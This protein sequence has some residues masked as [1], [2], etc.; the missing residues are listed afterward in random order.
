MGF[1]TIRNGIQRTMRSV[2]KRGY[3]ATLKLGYGLLRAMIIDRWDLRFDRRLGIDTL[4]NPA[5][6]EYGSAQRLIFSR[7]MRG[8]ALDFSKFV[9][10]DLGCGKG[11]ALIL[12]ADLPFQEIIGVEY[13]QELVRTARRNL[14]HVAAKKPR[15]RDVELLCMDAGEYILP[16]RNIVLYL[17]DP[18]GP[19]VLCGVLSQ[20]Q[21]SMRRNPREIFVAYAEPSCEGFMASV[22]S[23]TQISAGQGY[24]IYRALPPAGD[25]RL[26]ADGQSGQTP[27]APQRTERTIHGE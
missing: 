4:A 6:P 10:I 18:F 17:Y 14:D 2:R 20:I 19:E 11:K 8:L 7:I 3:S 23:L 9:F 16:D 5:F 22:G 15:L 13:Q 24:A 25:C 12:A 21:L 1:T 27:Q 26:P